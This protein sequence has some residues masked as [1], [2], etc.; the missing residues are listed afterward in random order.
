MKKIIF[1]NFSAI[2]GILSMMLLVSC[3]GGGSSSSSG[4]GSDVYGAAVQGVVTQ[5][6]GVAMMAPDTDQ[7]RLAYALQ[8]VSDRVL[9]TANALAG[10]LVTIAGLT[11]TTDSDG[12][13]YVKGVPPGPTPVELKYGNATAT[14]IINIPPNAEEVYLNDVKVEGN[15][16]VIGSMNVEVDDDRSSDDSVSSDDGVS[17]DDNVSSDDGV[18]SDDSSSSSTS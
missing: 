15:N 18:S 1:V 8:S 5:F 2:A 14:T 7:S 4:G 17:S 9:S 11:T 10:V 3:S 13:F 16:I 6:N 12:S